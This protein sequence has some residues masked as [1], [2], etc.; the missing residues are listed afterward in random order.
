MWYYIV[1]NECCRQCH[2][3]RFDIS[4]S[5]YDMFAVLRAHKESYCFTFVSY[6][7]W[8]NKNWSKQTITFYFHQ[9]SYFSVAFFKLNAITVINKLLNRWVDNELFTFFHALWIFSSMLWYE[10]FLFF[11]FLYSHVKCNALRKLNSIDDV[12]FAIKLE[13]GWFWI[14][15]GEI[16]NLRFY[17]IKKHFNN[18]YVCL[19]LGPCGGKTTGQARM[20]TFFENLGWKVRYP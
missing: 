20:C 3:F 12:T 10:L 9:R 5:R 11:F 18:V 6:H 13:Y 7:K 1:M 16:I 15:K 17:K 19:L 2:V 14:S 4:L 8:W